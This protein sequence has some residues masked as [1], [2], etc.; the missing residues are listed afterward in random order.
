[1][2]FVFYI[3][4]FV[5]ALTGCGETKDPDTLHDWYFWEQ[6]ETDEPQI[7]N[8]TIGIVIHKDGKEE[9]TK[10]DIPRMIDDKVF[11]RLLSDN[12]STMFLNCALEPDGKG[13]WTPL[14]EA[15]LHGHPQFH[16]YGQKMR[17]VVEIFFPEYDETHQL[18][19][20]RKTIL[21]DVEDY[22][23]MRKDLDARLRTADNLIVQG[24]YHSFKV[25]NLK[26]FRQLVKDNFPPECQLR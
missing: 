23:Q 19:D 3:L 15:W 17:S 21:N 26:R 4:I 16:V 10:A 13:G 8:M 9:L 5:F 18:G 24:G 20:W 12:Y 14:S 6:A 2:R 11:E 1:M 7:K 22:A 25:E